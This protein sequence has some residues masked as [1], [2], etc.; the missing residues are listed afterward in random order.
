MTHLQIIV[1]HVMFATS[2]LVRAPR[3]TY[4][5]RQKLGSKMY[6]IMYTPIE[7]MFQPRKKID[8]NDGRIQQS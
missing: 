2:M 1:R 4:S 7:Q 6:V 3:L 8:V 5:Q